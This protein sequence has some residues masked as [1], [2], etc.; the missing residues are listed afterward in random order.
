MGI[1]IREIYVN[2]E[3]TPP[4]N[5]REWRESMENG[6]AHLLPHRYKLRLKGNRFRFDTGGKVQDLTV[7]R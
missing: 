2:V 3:L 1:K 4:A 5:I 6:K 7:T